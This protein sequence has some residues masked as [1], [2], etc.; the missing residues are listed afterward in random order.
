M[1]HFSPILLNGNGLKREFKVVLASRQQ[2]CLLVCCS[3]LYF[4]FGK[5][6]VWHRTFWQDENLSDTH[7]E[8]LGATWQT[9][10]P[11]SWRFYFENHG[12]QI[13]KHWKALLGQLRH[14]AFACAGRTP[15]LLWLSHLLQVSPVRFLSTAALPMD[16]I[17]R[18]MKY[19]RSRNSWAPRFTPEPWDHLRLLI[20]L[21]QLATASHNC[22][23]VAAHNQR[24]NA[25]ILGKQ[26]ND[27]GKWRGTERRNYL[28]RLPWRDNLAMVRQS[29]LARAALKWGVDF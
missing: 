10:L 20:R 29:R 12:L 18:S 26:D 2:C 15:T 6:K 13:V 21:P 27:L 7:R 8:L 9:H 3:K 11:L 23:V 4:T 28:Q 5:G 16:H 19:E 14:G 25:G 22:F 24:R 17:E 1:M